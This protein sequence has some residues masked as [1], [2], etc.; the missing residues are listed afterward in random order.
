M[1]TREFYGQTED[2]A[3]KKGLD[4]LKLTK[5]Q[6]KI[7]VGPKDEELQ[8]G[9]KEKDNFVAEFTFE[10]EFQ[11]GNRALMQ[12]RD[13]LEKMNIEA[14]IYLIEEGDDKIVIEIESPDSAIIIG[15]QGK[16]LEALQTIINFIMNKD[17]DYWTKIVIDIGNYRERR[18]SYL[19]KVANQSIAAVKRSKKSILLEP[20]NP[21][22]RR[23]IHLNVK[24]EENVDTIS[25]GEGNI[26]RIKVFYTEHKEER[27]ENNNE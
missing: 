14:K 6:T 22:E 24:K 13:L 27:K 18:E 7:K 25:E 2:E 10:D 4:I 23:I 15:K 26:K 11:F 17:S 8:F 5:E 21:F 1:T 20:M 16:T 3:I 9:K 12:V 19:T